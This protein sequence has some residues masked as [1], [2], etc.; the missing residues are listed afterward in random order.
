MSLQ[1]SI[2][3]L[4]PS[5]ADPESFVNLDWIEAAEVFEVLGLPEIFNPATPV[6]IRARSLGRM[7]RGA[8]GG[9]FRD[10]AD[11][12]ADP[13]VATVAESYRGAT[14]RKLVEV[15]ALCERAG[16]LGVIIIE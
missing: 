3:T 6:E 4:R 2:R 7:V 10:E 15:Q 9:S 1:L 14:R 13:R 5:W 12:T 16:D 8:L 11:W